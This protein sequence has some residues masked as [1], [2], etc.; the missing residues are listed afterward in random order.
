[1][2]LIVHKRQA[3]STLG[4]VQLVSTRLSAC[5]ICIT[6]KNASAYQAMPECHDITLPQGILSTRIPWNIH[7][8]LLHQRYY[9]IP[10]CLISFGN[11]IEHLAGKHQKPGRVKMRESKQTCPGQLDVDISR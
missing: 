8:M 6:R 10:E 7:T 4:M 5:K 11:F 1:M 2:H 9:K 3:E